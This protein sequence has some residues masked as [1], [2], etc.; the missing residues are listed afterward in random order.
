VLWLVGR[1]GVIYVSSDGANFERVPF[2]DSSDLLSVV[3][4]NSREATVT[5][6]DG[7]TL[8]TTDRGVTWIS[9]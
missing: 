3:A 1:G 5:T 9:P 2:V 7:R 8:R 4:V 6:I